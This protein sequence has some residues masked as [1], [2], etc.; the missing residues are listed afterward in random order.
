MLEE[1]CELSV[2]ISK[3]TAQEFS[4]IPAGNIKA[5]DC[6][7]HFLNESLQKRVKRQLESENSHV[8]LMID[9]SSSIIGFLS[10]TVNVLAREFAADSLGQ[11]VSSIPKTVPVFKV[12]M[13]GIDEK[14]QGNGFGAALLQSALADFAEL[15]YTLLVTKGVVV[16]ALKGKEGFYKQNGFSVIQED[17]D[18]PT[19]TMFLPMTQLVEAL[20]ESVNVSKSK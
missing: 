10:W 15:H 3:I 5:F 14:F 6:G 17:D 11:S 9:E 1:K 4:Q 7:D 20:E 16:D 18:S 19:V 8:L 13:I 2:I 12:S